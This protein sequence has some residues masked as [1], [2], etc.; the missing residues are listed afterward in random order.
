MVVVAD[1]SI[2]KKLWVAI[3]VAESLARDTG[4]WSALI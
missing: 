1:E 2:L 3:S 4:E